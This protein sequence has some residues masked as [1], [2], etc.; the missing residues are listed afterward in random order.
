LTLWDS[1]GD[2]GADVIESPDPSQTL[3]AGRAALVAGSLD[4]AALR[5]GLA[6][7]LAPALAP[8]VLEATDG[9]RAPALIVVRGDAYRLVGH[10]AEARA[11]YAL[12][13]QGGLP[14]RRKASRSRPKVKAAEAEN[15]TIDDA[16]VT[17]VAGAT[18][19]SEAIE[20]T[21]AAGE[22]PD[23]MASIG[24]PAA[25]E[26]PAAVTEGVDTTASAQATA[27]ATEP[28]AAAPEQPDPAAA[29]DP[30]AAP[31]AP[32]ASDPPATPPED[33]PAG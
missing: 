28:A 33:A 24:A 22:A 15:V 9:V 27:S 21:G 20:A 3:E 26:D 1:D 32:A 6:L 5:F 25:T 2:T 19:A 18:E 7:R 13:A 16:E 29:P 11:A 17:E 23:A 8:A 12:A 31:D 10:E 14:D 4:E 30:D